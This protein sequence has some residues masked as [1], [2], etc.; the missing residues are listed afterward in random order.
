MDGG[1][2]ARCLGHLTGWILLPNVPLPFSC[3]RHAVARPCAAAL[4]ANKKLAFKCP[5]LLHPR[6]SMHPT[7]TVSQ[8]KGTGVDP[9]DLSTV[10]AGCLCSGVYTWFSFF[11]TRL[12][13]PVVA[14][15]NGLCA[16]GRPRRRDPADELE[17]W[18]IHTDT[19]SI[20][21]SSLT[22]HCLYSISPPPEHHLHLQLKVIT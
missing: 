9:C 10:V 3:L 16:R 22:F 13:K 20:I 4:A 11:S 8:R 15:Q 21:I 2:K 12:L 5:G 7:A 19:L 17:T 14:P 18:F 6:T 1:K